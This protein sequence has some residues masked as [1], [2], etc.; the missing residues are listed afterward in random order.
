MSSAPDSSCRGCGADELRGVSAFPEFMRVS[1]DCRP[2][3]SGGELALCGACGLVQK[4][5]TG[6]WKAE[7]REIYGSYALYAQASAGTEQKVFSSDGVGRPRTEHTLRVVFERAGVP[8]TGLA[9]DVGS[10][11]GAVL[12]ALGTV[13]PAWRCDAVEPNLRSRA[14]L[15]SIP[16]VRKVLA[17]ELAE[18]SGSYDL[19]TLF[20][21]LEHVPDLGPFLLD[22]RRLA[23]PGARVVVQVP[24]YGRNPFDLLVAD[25]CTHFSARTLTLALEASGLHVVV[26]DEETIAKELTVVCTPGSPMAR[27]EGDAAEVERA[28][29]RTDSAMEFLTAARRTGES[30][31][32]ADALGV[33]RSS[34]AA[35]WAASQLG[36]G[37]RFFVDEDD[38]RRGGIHAG[39]PIV[40][41]AEVAAGSTVLVIAPGEVGR[42]IAGRLARPGVA[43]VTNG[44]PVEDSIPRGER[45][46][47][48]L[49]EQGY[50]L[51]RG[52]V[53]VELLE[54]VRRRLASSAADAVAQV[55]RHFGRDAA[56]L[57]TG[58]DAPSI[59]AL[60][61]ALQD[62]ISGNF[63]PDVK[64]D[65]S[66]LELLRTPKLTGVLRSVLGSDRLFV[67]AYPSPRFVLPSN[68]LAAVPRH[69]DRQYNDHLSRFVT[70]W[71]PIDCFFRERGGVLLY[72]KSHTDRAEGTR[73]RADGLWF[74]PVSTRGRAGV[75]ED[76]A[77]GD[78][79]LLHEGVVHESVPNTSDGTRLSIDFR[80][81]GAGD[82]STKH[83]VALDTMILHAPGEGR[84]P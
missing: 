47:R 11:T 4:A 63:P 7:C 38:A 22:L 1:S 82:T 10:G 69:R 62:A 42:R 18:V 70:V 36:G 41:P 73:R 72:P 74:E 27:P 53:P 16:C 19:I 20:H 21:V 32:G 57:C 60:P 58:L 23:A 40:A 3:R 81:F 44:S 46:A 26:L 56:S 66:L 71:V 59:S 39:L 54:A 55:E 83:H 65:H 80:V 78:V 14:A 50:A 24:S 75:Q 13:R 48:D 52:V 9:L 28:S 35:T 77:P 29:E 25:H 33:F 64:G 51:V 67:H 68:N 5:A 31:R 45:A 76:V 17:M 84:A 37:V 30:V 79:L 61:R 49:A 34:I 2:F 8:E 43:Y 6:V 12:R 15:E